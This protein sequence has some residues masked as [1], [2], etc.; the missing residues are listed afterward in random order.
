MLGP[1]QLRVPR[2]LGTCWF[3]PP[4]KLTRMVDQLLKE[5]GCKIVNRAEW[6]SSSAAE[7]AEAVRCDRND[8]SRARGLAVNSD[9]RGLVAEVL[10]DERPIVVGEQ[11]D[12]V[13]RVE[14]NREV[15]EQI[16]LDPSHHRLRQFVQVA[17][18]LGHGPE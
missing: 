7:Q 3:P 8:L 12:V 5:A 9:E 2:P 13:G 1:L 17:E 10:D 14:L 18:V 15:A 16:L 6:L 4:V 11:S